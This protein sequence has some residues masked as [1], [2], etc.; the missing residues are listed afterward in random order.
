MHPTVYWHILRPN[1]GH[2][3]VFGLLIGFFMLGPSSLSL[4][5]L[6][7]VIAAFLIGGGGNVINDYFDYEIDR[8]NKPTRILPS[9]KISRKNALM[10]FG[11]LN[12]LGLLLAYLVNLQFFGIAVLNSMVSL[13]YAWKLKRTALIGNIA[14]SWLASATFL[15]GGLVVASVSEIVSSPLMLLAAIAFLVT[16]GREIYKDIEDVKGDKALG[17]ATMPIA[18]GITKSMRI[19][20]MLVILGALFAIIPY[21]NKTFNELYLVAVLPSIIILL[22]AVKADEPVKAQKTLKTGMLLGATAFLIGAL[23]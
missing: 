7:A 16:M 22:Y 17:A 9:G 19:A 1:V 2:L 18:M 6:F 3:A 21:L 15:A 8:I 13:G 11:L 23:L 20:K 12:T 14:D 10:Y 4:R 5:L